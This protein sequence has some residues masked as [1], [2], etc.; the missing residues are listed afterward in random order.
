MHLR[1]F[2]ARHSEDGWPLGRILASRLS[3]PIHRVRKL[4][5]ERMVQVDGRPCHKA[6]RRL[7]AGQ[8][9]RIVV[10]AHSPGNARKRAAAI[11]IRYQDRH[12]LVVDKP[13]GLTTMRHAHEAAEFGPRG[14]HYLPKT[15]MDLLKEQLPGPLRKSI[16]AVHRLDK[17][18]SGLLVFSLSPLAKDRL[19][20]QFRQ[21]TIQRR[22]LAVVRGQPISQHVESNIVRDRGDGR[23]GSGPGPG[24]RAVT[25]VRLL[26]QLSGFAVVECSLETG[27]TH[28]V[29]IHL[30]E[31]G[32]PL[33]GETVYDR[34]LHGVP[35]PRDDTG[36]PRPA[37]HA[38]FLG[39]DH[40]VTG[41]RLSFAAPPPADFKA[42]VK[43][44]RAAA[45]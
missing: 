18:T 14:R 22:Y 31:T 2:T 27:R 24:Q 12:V 45:R 8:S 44:L 37:L 26:E 1:S 20:T 13:P 16:G 40:P 23:R 43:R 21:H 9:I 3:M 4:I 34:P 42:L 5:R 28:Q 38:A 19:A 6:S 15:L 17:E 10:P 30:G 25:H 35:D 29:R 7:H 33:V 41:R 39:F 36:F 32:T 11:P